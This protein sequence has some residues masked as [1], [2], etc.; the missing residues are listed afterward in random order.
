VGTGRVGSGIVHPKYRRLI[1]PGVL[2][3]LLLIVVLAAVL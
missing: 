1:I 2:G 3:I